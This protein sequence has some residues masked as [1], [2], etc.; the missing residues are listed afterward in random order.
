MS[1]K[2]KLLI[3]LKEAMK[4]KDRIKKDTIQMVRSAILQIEKDNKVELQDDA[5]I[6]VLSKEIKRRRDALSEFEKSDRADLIENLKREISILTLYLPEQLSED[7]LLKIISEAVQQV[8]AKSMKDI[9]MIMKVV[10]PQIKGKA[11]GR[12]VNTLIKRIFEG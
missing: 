9:G 12:L 10:L 4:E 3:D 11:D 6:E 7:E 1:L 5:I 2:D 8:G